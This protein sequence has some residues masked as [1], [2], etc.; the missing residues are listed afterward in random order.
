MLPAPPLPVEPDPVLLSPE[1]AAPAGTPP[2]M[3]TGALTALAGAHQAH[4][5]AMADLH[6]QFIAQ[7]QAA[8]ARILP[9]RDRRRQP[10]RTPPGAAPVTAGPSTVARAAD[11]P[12]PGT[13]LPGPTFTRV[14]LEEL[15]TMRRSVSSLLGGQFARQDAHRYQLRVPAPPMLFTD[16]VLG[17]EGT[18]GSLGSGRLWAEVDLTGNMFGLDPAGRISG[19]LLGE[20]GQANMLL[21]SWLGADLCHDGQSRYRMLDLDLTLHGALPGAGETLRTEITLERQAV[22]GG[23]RVFFFGAEATAGGRLVARARFSAGLFTEADLV[24]P[25]ELN[26]SPPHAARAAG[27]PFE[28]AEEFTHT[29]SFGR[30]AL[31]A[32]REGRIAD[33]FGETHRRART[34]VRTPRAALRELFLLDSV[35]EL[36]PWGGPGG[37]GYLRATQVVTPHDWYFAAHLPGD[38]CMPG[39]LML[40]GAKQALAFYL[41]AMGLTIPRDGWRF[42][43]PPGVTAA[44]RFRG[45]V[46]P[47]AATIVYE[48]FVTS[49]SS[50]PVPAVVADVICRLDGRIVFHG[51]DVALRLIPDWPLEQFRSHPYSGAL[52]GGT[53]PLPVLAGLAGR[54]PDPE[55]ASVDGIESGYP[56]LLALA[57]GKAQDVFG[58]RMAVLDGPLRWARL[59]APPFLFVT[60]VTRIEAEAAVPRP[61]SRIRTCW[62]IPETAWF[63]AEN[64]TPTMPFAVMIEALLQ[65]PGWLMA[66]VGPLAPD[67]RPFTGY[68][69]NLDG[70]AT[71]HR[72][73]TPGTPRLEVTVELISMVQ[74]GGTVLFAMQMEGSVGGDLICEIRATYG[75]FSAQALQEQVGVPA[76]AEEHARIRSEGDRMIDLAAAPDRY[77]SGTLRLPGPRLLMIDRVTAID[78]A[79]GAAG[80]GWARAEKPVD[81]E[82]WF[83]KA[84]FFQDPVQPGSLGLEM[85]IQLLQVVMIELGL[86]ASVPR[87]RFG[88]VA[89]GH[90]LAWKYRGQV[91]PEN[92]CVVAEVEL[93]EAG[94]DDRGPFVI[95]NGWLWVDGTRVYQVSGIGMR[96]LPGPG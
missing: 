68:L 55:A 90:E 3:A 87:A 20:A 30:A 13:A 47:Q 73:L 63:F 34:H 78:P 15:A 72:E 11:P 83:F 25:V 16:R 29:R 59:P 37:L 76:T 8:A 22:A 48:V 81:P 19:L 61:G 39:F 36:E 93:T 94:H 75:M 46:V 32:L 50:G 7:Q 56:S 12:G 70:I 26:W 41:T 14:Q 40:E 64:G 67:G 57:W 52:G 66:F 23:L 45:Q 79:G 24:R 60:R 84:H 31:A 77:F 92:R 88:P 74:L 42:E 9:L 27:E 89:T 85:L 10:Q 49:V 82:E 4:L 86:G 38:P 96:I 95:A 44:C 1:W 91:L 18:P 71:V 33:C 28:V 17:I 62:E 80:L 51:G 6:K 58:P 43:P 21:A 5:L 2:A 53:G 65:P 35:E 69:R 54:R